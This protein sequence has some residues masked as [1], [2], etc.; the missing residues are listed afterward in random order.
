[1]LYVRTHEKAAQ[2]KVGAGLENAVN[3][4]QCQDG[5]KLLVHVAQ[6]DRKLQRQRGGSTPSDSM[7][8]SGNSTSDKH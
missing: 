4:P 5:N 6:L 1:V 2:V 7:W 3:L 8:Q